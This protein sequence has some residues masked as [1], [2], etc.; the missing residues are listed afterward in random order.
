MSRKKKTKHNP[1]KQ[2]KSNFIEFSKV[3]ENY[4]TE[5]RNRQSRELN[6]AIESIYRELNLKGTPGI[7]RLRPDFSGLDILPTKSEENKDK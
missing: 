4:L 2:P 6:E 3:Q 1:P 7:Y 5:V